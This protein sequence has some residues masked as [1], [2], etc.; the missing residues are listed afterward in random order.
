MDQA[1]GPVKP[2]HHIAVADLLVTCSHPP[3]RSHLT[4]AILMHQATPELPVEHIGIRERASLRSPKAWAQPKD[5]WLRHVNLCSHHYPRCIARPEHFRA[6]LLYC[7]RLS[8]PP[9]G[10]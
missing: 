10:S 4:K 1:T 9:F 5:I 2:V 6:R 8:V 3:V 7:S